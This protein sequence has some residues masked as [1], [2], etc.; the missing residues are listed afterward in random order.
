MIIITFKFVFP[1]QFYGRL[2]LSL[3][4]MNVILRSRYTSYDVSLK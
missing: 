1:I 3:A 4:A 2:Q